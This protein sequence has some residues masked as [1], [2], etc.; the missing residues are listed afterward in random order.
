MEEEEEW[1][2]GGWDS[3]ELLPSLS[4]AQAYKI[5]KEIIDDNATDVELGFP[6]SYNPEN[7][8]DVYYPEA[9]VCLQ[10]SLLHQLSQ[11]GGPNS[12]TKLESLSAS[13][14]EKS[15]GFHVVEQS[16]KQVFEAELKR[17]RY[18][19]EFHRASYQSTS[20]EQA[21]KISRLEREAREFESIEKAL[22]ARIRELEE[23]RGQDVAKQ[24][25]LKAMIE[26]SDKLLSIRVEKLG[27]KVGAAGKWSDAEFKRHDRQFKD[28]SEFLIGLDNRVNRLDANLSSINEEFVKASRSLSDMRGEQSVITRGMRRGVEDLNRRLEGLER[29]CSEAESRFRALNETV[30]SSIEPMGHGQV[31]LRELE[32]RVLRFL[33]KHPDFEEKLDDIEVKQKGLNGKEAMLENLSWRL[34]VV[35]CVCS[36]Y[37]ARQA[38]RAAKRN[39]ERTLEK[40]A[41]SKPSLLRRIGGCFCA[42]LLG[43]MA[44]FAFILVDEL[45][46]KS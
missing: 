30:H 27:M 10:P 41:V 14:D 12:P 39:E 15:G 35:E 24:A 6:L 17:L 3:E 44:I 4:R 22:K 20:S 38:V 13:Q 28:I 26:I 36:D 8:F 46:W 16:P 21:A 40:T 9:G 45:V 18:E 7:E 43:F 34:H 32:E 19:L 1:G 25:R 29:R 11:Y 31:R 23:L 33:G 37:K 2:Q 5:R 42:F